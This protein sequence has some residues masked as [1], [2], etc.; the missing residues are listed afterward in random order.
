MTKRGECVEFSYVSTSLSKNYSSVTTTTRSRTWSIY[1]T[2]PMNNQ[3]ISRPVHCPNCTKVVMKE[4]VVNGQVDF[5]TK[6]PLCQTYFTV[7][8]RMEPIIE[9]SKSLSVA[10][11][12]DSKN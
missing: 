7:Q 8:V 2:K 3:T 12:G 5:T 10:F 11:I 1:H 6:C 4:L 9:I